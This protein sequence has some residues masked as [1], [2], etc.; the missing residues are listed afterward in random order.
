MKKASIEGDLGRHLDDVEGCQIDRHDA[1]RT[2]WSRSEPGIEDWK[3]YVS[4]SESIGGTR[5]SVC[6]YHLVCYC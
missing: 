2:V 5:G 1:Q 4:V 6:V 3:G